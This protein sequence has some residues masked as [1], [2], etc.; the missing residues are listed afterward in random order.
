M[1]TRTKRGP[2]AGKSNRGQK[3]ARTHQVYGTET[4]LSRLEGVKK[5]GPQ[6]WT[7]KCPSHAD[8]SPSL[9]VRELDD[10]RTLL[11]CFAGCHAEEVLSAVGLDMSALF[12]D[13]LLP[14]GG[15]ASPVKRAWSANELIELAAHKAA[16]VVLATY[17]MLEGRPVD[18]DELISAARVLGDIHEEV[19][20]GHH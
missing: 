9:A 8:K 17:D 13:R 10:G 3:Q 20:R 6:A 15:G 2:G 7:A 5:A 12:P 18:R 11:H 1:S 14:A 19:T 4:L 16:V